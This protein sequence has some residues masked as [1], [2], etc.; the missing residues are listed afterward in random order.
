MGPAAPPPLPGRLLFRLLLLL[1]ALDHTAFAVGVWLRPGDVFAFLHLPEIAPGQ[2]QDRLVLLQALGLL[3]LAHAT[4][5]VILV[6]WPERLG[7]LALV[8]LVGRLLGAAVWLWA[9]AADRFDVPDK[10]YPLTVLAL[11]EA[12]WVA[13]LAGF[14]FAW[15]RWQRHTVVTPSPS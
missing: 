13:A 5:L 12:V 7:P 2:P 3:A 9:L 10:A 15:Y 11:H 8:A 6:C 4:V 1:A 14:L